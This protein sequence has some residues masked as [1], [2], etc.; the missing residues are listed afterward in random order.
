MWNFTTVNSSQRQYFFLITNNIKLLYILP[1]LSKDKSKM[2]ITIQTCS[3]CLFWAQTAVPMEV[4]GLYSSESTS[5]KH[6]TIKEFS[7]INILK[8]YY[9][10]VFGNTYLWKDVFENEIHETLLQISTNR[11]ISGKVEIGKKKSEITFD[12]KK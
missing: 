9:L 5:P 12:D 3:I 6:W 8:K 7:V 10:S 2:S 11:R 4:S 1:V